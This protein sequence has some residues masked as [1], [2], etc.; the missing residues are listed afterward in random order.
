MEKMYYSIRETAEIVGEAESTLR[1]WESEFQD[2]ISPKRNEGGTR[3]YAEKD[4]EDVR[5]V[6]FLLRDQKL[7]LDGAR[8]ALKNNRDDA[9]KQAKMMWHLQRI[10]S[11]LLA[12][13]KAFDEAEKIRN[14]A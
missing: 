3:F 14:G 1:Y 2:I 13:R 8:N 6:Q 7:T 9:V 11:E 12:L 4:M 10:R 5:L